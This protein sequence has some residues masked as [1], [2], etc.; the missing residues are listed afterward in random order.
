MGLLKEYEDLPVE[1]KLAPEKH[2][3]EIFRRVD[4]YIQHA[5]TYYLGEK[6]EAVRDAV[7]NLRNLGRPSTSCRRRKRW[8][9]GRDG[10]RKT[11]RR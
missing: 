1:W 4:D 2:L 7:R 6:V 3:E 9:S 11:A 5:E 8:R 10:S